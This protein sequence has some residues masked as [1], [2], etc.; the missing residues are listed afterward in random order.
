MSNTNAKAMTMPR[1]FSDTLE[2]DPLATSRW[3]APENVVQALPFDP[4]KRDSVLLGYVPGK[5]KLHYVGMPIDDRHG[6]TIAGARSGKGTSFIVP[7]LLLYPGSVIAND[8][9]GELARITSRRRK[10]MGQAV[11]IIDPFLDSGIDESKLASFNPLDII[12]PGSENAA[13]DAGLLADALVVQESGSGRHWT[14]AARNFLHGVILYVAL[15]CIGRERTLPHVRELITLPKEE[16]YGAGGL[17]ER[18]QE[19]GGYCAQAANSLVGKSENECSSVLST[20]LEQTAF[21]ASPAMKRGLSKS[22]FDID[23]LKNSR[24][25]LTVY[26][27]LPG[28][29]LRTHS[30]FMRLM[31]MVALARM[32]AVPN[33]SVTQATANGWPVL[34][35]LDEFPVLGHMDVIESAAGLMAGYGV[36]LWTVLQDLS[37]LQRDYPKSWQ[38]FLGNT[39]IIQNFGSTDEATCTYMSKL[40]GE[41]ELLSQSFPELTERERGAGKIGLNKSVAVNPL[42]RPDEVRRLFAR[43]TGRALLSIPGEHPTAVMRANYFDPQHSKLFGGKYD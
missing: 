10:E 28:T 20:A 13:D 35:M 9:K 21:L 6:V 12:Q 2:L 37:Q 27:C 36:K 31:L 5:G 8:P 3:M 38:T 19:A 14:T 11:A 34:F 24:A 33:V 32:E 4:K 15:R 1:G 42:I 18:M 30:R 23:A 26:L 7:N 22:T 16:F 39:G 25:G 41:T 29:R 40:C 43:Q 17:I